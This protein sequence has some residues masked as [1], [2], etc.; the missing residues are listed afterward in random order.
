MVT[1][2]GLQSNFID[3]LKEL[4]QLGYDVVVAYEIAIN[5]LNAPEYKTSL[6]NFKEDHEYHVK[7]FSNY[8]ATNGEIPPAVPR[9]KSLLKQG[10]VVLA[11]LL[12][13]RTILRTMK[14]NE[15]DTN[16]AYER[17]NNYENIPVEIKNCIKK[18]LEDER[19]HAAWLDNALRQG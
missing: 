16:K 4:V 17:L 14:S 18:A 10:K 3:A 15:Q 19:R 9:I 2:I 5:R 8:L 11:N 13:D 12:G 7:V 1:T 6:Q